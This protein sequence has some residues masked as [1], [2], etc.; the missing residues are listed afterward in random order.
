M[1]APELLRDLFGR[2]REHVTGVLDGVAPADLTRTLTPTSN[3]I[4]W[5]L[6]H[7]ARVQDVH[8]AEAWDREQ[9]WVE[10][11]WWRRFGLDDD[12]HN[13]GYG[14]SPDDVARVRPDSVEALKDYFE[15]VAVRGD[16]LLATVTA[17]DLERIVDDSWDPPV[18]LGVRLV[19]I[20]DDQIQHAGQAAYLRGVLAATAT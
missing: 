6:W 17:E 15:E 16:E 10:G 2:V 18:T 11:E 8:M 19:S 7:L 1:E 4:G 20:A 13:H 3:H 12:P 14:H 9:V 5:L